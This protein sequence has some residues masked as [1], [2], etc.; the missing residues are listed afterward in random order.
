MLSFIGEVTVHN[1][2]V[3]LI[4][5]GN[6]IKLN[7]GDPLLVGDVIVAKNGAS[8]EIALD[9]NRVIPITSDDYLRLDASVIGRIESTDASDEVQDR[10]NTGLLGTQNVDAEIAAI[11]EAL[12]EGNI[13]IDDLA[14]TAAGGSAAANSTEGGEYDA[15]T[16]AYGHV[17]T[18]QL[19]SDFSVRLITDNFDVY[20]QGLATITALEVDTI[21]DTLPDT[22]T[23][24]DT[25]TDIVTAEDTVTIP[26]ET[27]VT[28]S[29]SDITE[30]ESTITDTDYEYT[31]T[32]SGEDT[33]P[34]TA[35]DSYSDFTDTESTLTDTDYKYT[36]T[37]SG[38]DE[39]V[40]TITTQTLDFTD[41]ITTIPD[42]TTT[43]VPT[44]TM[45]T[46]DTEFTVPTS[47]TT[48]IETEYETLTDTESTLTDTD[49]KYTA[50]ESGE[51]ET[52]T[53]I[54]TQTLDFTDTITTI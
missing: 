18:L 11:Q 5:D 47:T 12:L 29:F 1:G 23:A 17:D 54:T 9:N 32:E 10:D 22:E 38:E 45:D 26:V 43:T 40:T 37:E 48:L 35:T 44:E 33:V 15:R 7:S 2:T 20:R 21:T 8:A 51:D 52:V 53:T 42:T 27:T 25:F 46:T 39:T 50:T 49:Y 16:N 13:N 19:G 36:A 4:R 30:F 24:V 41:T 28:Q 14:K 31:A 3:D 6:V 34:T